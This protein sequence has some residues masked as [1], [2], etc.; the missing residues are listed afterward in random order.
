[1]RAPEPLLRVRLAVWVTAGSF[2][3]VALGL[4]ASTLFWFGLLSNSRMLDL[5]W[6]VLFFLVETAM[7][8][9]VAVSMFRQGQALQ[10]LQEDPNQ[11]AAMT[12]VLSANL[13]FWRALTVGAI[14][15]I[16]LFL[17]GMPPAISVFGS[18]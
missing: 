15:L 6:A 1:M 13:L 9:L 7:A 3:I 5:L 16:W 12:E 17:I 2:A 4:L 10:R 11:N 14:G 18:D 8:A